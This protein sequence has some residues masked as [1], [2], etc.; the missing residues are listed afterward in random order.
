MNEPSKHFEFRRQLAHVCF[1]VILLW[2]VHF[3]L[4]NMWTMFLLLIVVSFML[5]KI[6]QGKHIP[7]F[8][9]LLQFFE[10]KK[11]FERFPGRGLF[12]FLLGTWVLTLF[13]EKL[14]I[15]AS[16]SI[17][18]IG[19][20]VTN[21]AGNHIGKIKNP[22]NKK[23]TLEGTLAGI[24]ASYGVCMLFYP[25]I[26]SFVAA[27]VAMIIEAPKWKIKKIPIDDNLTIPVS[28][29]VVLYV[30]SL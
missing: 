3:D 9:P 20:A 10:R 21:V 1:G 14:I 5:Y 27:T 12:Y 18:L 6:K 15:L 13:F 25:P 4:V 26:I 2:G 17:L 24:V 8:S 28:S 29:A 22:L 16:L 7:I 11:H 30:F 19:D 23:K